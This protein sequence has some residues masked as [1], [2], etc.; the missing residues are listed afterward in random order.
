[1]KHQDKFGGYWRWLVINFS[2]MLE[3][4]VEIMYNNNVGCVLIYRAYTHLYTL[5]R[6]MNAQRMIS[7]FCYAKK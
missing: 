4:K 5:Y 1:M 6:K 3:K 2:K 7:I